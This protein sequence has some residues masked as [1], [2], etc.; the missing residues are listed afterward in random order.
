[1][2]KTIT[3]ILVLLVYVCSFG[4]EYMWRVPSDTIIHFEDTIKRIADAQ[5]PRGRTIGRT[6]EVGTVIPI[7]TDAF[8]WMYFSVPTISIILSPTT[9]LYEVGTTNSI[10]IISTT[11]NPSSATLSAGVLLN[12]TDA[13]TIAS[14]GATPSNTTTISFEPLEAR[15]T[16]YEELLYHFRTSQ[17]WVSGSEGATMS[18]NIYL[19]G[20]FPIYH[21]V[22]V[23]DYSTDLTGIDSDGGIVETLAL[24]GNKVY[25]VAGIGHVYYAMPA[26][27]S[28]SVLTE[29]IDHNAFNNI[30]AYTRYGPL[31]LTTGNWTTTYYI[32]QLDVA[33]TEIVDF[34]DWQFNR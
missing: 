6:W 16:P 25:D 17:T 13:Q 9:T 5:F 10:D 31:S 29:I 3:L 15:T 28:N 7:G 2:K 8:D 34:D 26:E 18:A 20:A 4:Q 27:W 24:E 22:S 32:Y 33:L 30:L 23:T 14:Y 11:T 21:G 19:Y 12:M 1:M